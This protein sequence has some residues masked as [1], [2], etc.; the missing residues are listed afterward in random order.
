MQGES[1]LECGKLAKKPDAAAESAL[2]LLY[3][4]IWVLQ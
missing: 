2:F 3:F 4:G 1:A